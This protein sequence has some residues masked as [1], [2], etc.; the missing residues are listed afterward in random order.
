MFGAFKTQTARV[1]RTVTPEYKA[2]F[3]PDQS[4]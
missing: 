2:L 3:G 1:V 4:D